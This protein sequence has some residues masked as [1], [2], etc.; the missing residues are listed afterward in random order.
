MA[1]DP[2]IAEAL[3]WLRD[4]SAELDADYPALQ[5]RE[6]YYAG[7]HPMAFATSR[8][9]DTFGQLF[10]P[11]ADNWCPTVVEASAE[12]LIVDGFRFG[13]SDEE[14]K[15]ASRV[16][17]ANNM[18]ARSAQAHL[19]ACKLGRVYVMVE[20]RGNRPARM[21]VEHPTQVI[22][23][24]DEGDRTQRLAALKRWKQRDG[25]VNATIYL[26]D[27]IYKLQTKEA[28]RGDH[29]S[30][31]VEWIPRPDARYLVKNPLGIVPVVPLYNEPTLLGT[32]KSDLDTV[33][34]IQDAI[35]KLVMDMIVASEFAAFRQRWATGIEI[36]EDDDG[37]PMAA[38]QFLSSVAS[39][40]AVE[41][42]NARFGEF[43]ASDLGNY[44]TGIAMLIQHMAAQTRT[45]VHYMLAEL[46]NVNAEALKV[47]ETGLTSK[48]KRK[49]LF[50]GEGWEEAVRIATG[51]SLDDGD[52]ETIWSDPE[53]RSRAEM[54]DALLKAKDL[55]IP[56]EILW[57]EYGLTAKQR[58]RA[59]K[60]RARDLANAALAGVVTPDGQGVDAIPEDDAATVAGA[61]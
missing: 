19:E 10:G 61:R 3:P 45:P 2:R 32:G 23:E 27:R 56:E 43:S 37:R 48:V 9:R 29:P 13:D 55:G 53:T 4:L 41:D 52:G 5:K 16:W 14:D 38:K 34:P 15:Q 20:P 30:G 7:K 54:A 46:V 24:H 8:F 59:R 17:Q 44:V 31:E 1:D 26:P 21:S 12:R 33:I 35:N 28:P 49:A 57:E 51:R 47:A 50:L 36:P 18:D 39:V 11:F 40:W 60:L 25:K 58:D 42:E 6:D 22:V